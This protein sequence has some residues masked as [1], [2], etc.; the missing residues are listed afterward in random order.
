MT[1]KLL[2]VI[3][4][5]FTFTA[6]PELWTEFVL[7]AQKKGHEV[8]CV[9]LRS[10]KIESEYE[11]VVNSIGKFCNIIFTSRNAKKKYLMDR[12]IYPNIWIDD[13]PEHI[14]K[15]AAPIFVE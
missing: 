10:H 7:S 3:D 15:S 11:E 12:G 2:I 1:K 14:F 6:D 5:D 9:T 4:Y 8:M 13:E